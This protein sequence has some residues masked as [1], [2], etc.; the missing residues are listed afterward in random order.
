M[1]GGGERDEASAGD[2]L[3]E[4]HERHEMQEA[5]TDR[6]SRG[7]ALDEMNKAWKL[8][9]MNKACKRTAT[10]NVERDE[11][12]KKECS[13]SNIAVAY[14][15]S[16]GEGFRGERV[17]VRGVGDREFGGGVDFA[18]E[19]SEVLRRLVSEGSEFDAS[20]FFCSWGT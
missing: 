8:D 13:E 7:D 16:R 4:R 1:G 2:E 18:G 20:L 5:Y 15:S 3:D 11:K 19:G 10:G 12:E 17:E 14:V 6:E 9:E